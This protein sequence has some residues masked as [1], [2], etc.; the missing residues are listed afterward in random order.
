MAVNYSGKSFYNTKPKTWRHTLSTFN[1]SK[2]AMLIFCHTSKKNKVEGL[3]Y[4]KNAD[5]AH[6]KMNK[7]PQNIV[8]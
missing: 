5:T 8:L 7:G 3:N 6:L 2:R 4:W 1:E